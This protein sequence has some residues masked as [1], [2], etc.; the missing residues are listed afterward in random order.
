MSFAELPSE[1]VYKI[2]SYVEGKVIWVLP[3]VCRRWREVCAEFTVKVEIRWHKTP[4]HFCGILPRF[5]SMIKIISD[6]YDLKDYTIILISHRPSVF[7]KCKKI[8]KVEEN[9]L[10]EVNNYKDLI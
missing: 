3:R 4:E 1:L 6:I 10:K 7:K 2:F 9:S 5:K 8:Y